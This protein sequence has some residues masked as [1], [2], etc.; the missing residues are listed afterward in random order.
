MYW[1]LPLS[2]RIAPVNFTLS[3]KYLTKLICTTYPFHSHINYTAKYIKIIKKSRKPMN[4]FL[5]LLYQ[6]LWVN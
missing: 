4:S 5:T 1:I 2:S 3:P 6:T